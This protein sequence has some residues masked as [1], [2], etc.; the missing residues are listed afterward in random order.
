MANSFA[1]RT[2]RWVAMALVALLLAYGITLGVVMWQNRGS[3]PLVSPTVEGTGRTAKDGFAPT[4]VVR[5]FPPI[6]DFPVVA[7][8]DV[9]EAIHDSELIFGVDIQGEARAYP[10]NM[11]T[12][13]QREILNDQL[14]GQA[15]AATW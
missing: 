6:T 3:A 1:I 15:I 8:A 14:G 12:S 9:G 2:L 10:I 5:P 11:L 7:T 4:Q 13:P